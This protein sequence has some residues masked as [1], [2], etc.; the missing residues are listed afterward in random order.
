MPQSTAAPFIV[1]VGGGQP[2]KGVGAGVLHA[3]IR[4]IRLTVALGLKM[5]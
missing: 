3:S 1:F 5:E 2:A 4:P